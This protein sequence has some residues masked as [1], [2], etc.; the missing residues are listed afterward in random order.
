MGR[1]TSES[2]VSCGTKSYEYNELNVRKKIINARGQIRQIFYD[3]MGR[4][5]GYTSPEGYGKAIRYEYD[6][7]GNLPKIIYPDNTAV[8]Y[9]YDANHN[10][11]RVTDWANRVTSYHLRFKDST[12]TLPEPFLI[13]YTLY[14]MLTYRQGVFE[15]FC[16][17]CVFLCVK[18][19]CVIDIHPDSCYHKDA[20]EA[21]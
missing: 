13:T 12:T 15:S 11:I 2:T 9:A 21:G 17:F 19:H 3:S 18:R 7:V 10:L 4:I 1:L 14:H 20:A 6:A 8:T 5:T 16:V